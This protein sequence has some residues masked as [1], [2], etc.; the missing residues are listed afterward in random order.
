MFMSRS[1]NVGGIHVLLWGISS[2]INADYGCIELE[3]VQ[4]N[5]ILKN[6]H[7]DSHDIEMCEMWARAK[8]TD[9]LF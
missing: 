8:G 7:L 1:L 9:S 6:G 5:A 4:I 3:N 2:L